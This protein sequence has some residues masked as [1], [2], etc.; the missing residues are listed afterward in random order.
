MNQ[1]IKGPGPMQQKYVV[2]TQK[3]IKGIQRNKPRKTKYNP[4]VTCTYCGK[5]GRVHDDCYWL[6]G[7]SEDFQFTKPKLYQGKANGVITGDETEVSHNTQAET[8]SN[9]AGGTIGNQYMSKDQYADLVQQVI[10]DAKLDKEDP[11]M[12]VSMLEP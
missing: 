8:G 10:K 11:L 4:N 1:S 12:V 5:T 9:N 2:S 7:F 3:N 6:I